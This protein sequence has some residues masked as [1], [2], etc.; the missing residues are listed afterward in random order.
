MPAASV[1]VDC[2]SRVLA[3]LVLPWVEEEDQPLPCVHDACDHHTKSLQSRTSIVL[4]V[5]PDHGGEILLEL[6]IRLGRSR[7][8]IIASE[9]SGE[10]LEDILIVKVRNRSKSVLR[11]ASL[12]DGVSVGLFHVIGLDAGLLSG[13]EHDFLPLRTI[14]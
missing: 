9:A 7:R 6:H 10:L 8:V 4:T 13:L 1:A 3:V 5:R 2:P 14:R 11:I 12:V